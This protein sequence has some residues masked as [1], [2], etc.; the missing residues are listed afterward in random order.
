[1]KSSAPAPWGRFLPPPQTWFLRLLI[2]LGAGRGFVRKAIIRKW[3]KLAPPLVDF[4]IRGV[5][6]RLEIAANTSDAKILTSSTLNNKRELDALAGAPKSP[7]SVFVDVGANTGY[8]S[9]MLAK[10]GF[11]R[12]IAIEPNPPTLERLRFN[13]AANDAAGSVEVVPYSVGPR[14]EIP[15]Y[16]SGGLGSASAIGKTGE[17]PACHVTALPLIDILRA[18]EI[19]RI[20]AM[21]IDVEGFEATV[22]LPFF[23]G[24]PRTL[25]PQV[26]VIEDCHRVHWSVDVIDHMVG[27]GYRILSRTRGN[28]LMELVP[29]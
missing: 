12:V 26:V 10:R 29:Q 15:F 22:L 16:S 27:L 7:A 6:F 14:G 20:D 13:I 24:A 3:R 9:L 18:M 25:W 5:R 1:M 4:E 17:S 21:K 8:Y 19:T 11:G 28:Q 2:H 23:S